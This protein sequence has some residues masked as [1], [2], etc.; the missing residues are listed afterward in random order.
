MKFTLSKTELSKLSTLVKTSQTVS[1]VSIKAAHYMFKLSDKLYASIYGS[2]NVVDFSVEATDIE[3]SGNGYFNV[4]VNQ[5]IQ[6]FEKV[7]MSSGA[8]T[9]TAEVLANKINV[10]NGK[11]RISVNLFDL[12]DEADFNEAFAA[13]PT[14]K[15]EKF[16]EDTISATITPDVVNFMETVGKFITMV[17]SDRVSGLALKDN[18]ILYCDQAFSIIE[19]TVEDTLTNGESVSVPQSAF[20]LLSAISKLAGKFNITYS[21]D[22]QYMLIEVPEIGFNAILTVP[23]ILCEYPGEDQ[24][25]MICPDPAQKLEFDV[26][27]STLLTKMNMFDGVFP[28]AQWRWKTIEFYNTL[29]D[30]ANGEAATM[31]MRYNNMCAEVDTDLPVT[32]LVGTGNIPEFSFRLASILI[33]DY[34]NKLVGNATAAH[35]TVSPIE[36]NMEHGVGVIFD[37]DNFRLVTSKMVNEESI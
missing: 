17:G 9:A 28:S 22:N 36:A 33:H 2:G 27:I 16:T 7:Y 4:D 13:L 24:L 1:D 6:A 23:E 14:K 37:V 26:D 12:L 29:A 3:L 15:T 34:L 11:S 5:L 19:K 30:D 8:E 10:S 35:V 31:N 18:K 25:Q 20:S 21:A 32:N